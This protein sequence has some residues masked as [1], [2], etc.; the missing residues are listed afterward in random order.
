[1]EKTHRFD[2]LTE[3]ESVLTGVNDDP[4]GRFEIGTTVVEPFGNSRDRTSFYFDRP[5]L[6]LSHVQYQI[7]LSASRSPIKVRLGFQGYSGEQIFDGKS[8]P[9]TPSHRMTEDVLCG[10]QPSKASKE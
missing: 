8:F 6:L 5:T 1:M 7:N 10:A 4:P 2:V 3:T 9:T